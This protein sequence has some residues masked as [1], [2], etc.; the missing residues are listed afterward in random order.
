[1]DVA[2]PSTL[3]YAD[4]VGSRVMGLDD[5]EELK[6]LVMHSRALGQ[7]LKSSDFVRASDFG[8]KVLVGGEVG[9]VSGIRVIVNNSIPNSVAIMIDPARY[10]EMID[11]KM[12]S[13]RRMDEDTDILKVSFWYPV[14]SGVINKNAAVLITNLA[15]DAASLA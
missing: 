15:S 3:A 14:G 7:I 6:V 10:A 5:Y 2:S 11:K 13:H 1:M 12:Y 8:D 4:I 9:K